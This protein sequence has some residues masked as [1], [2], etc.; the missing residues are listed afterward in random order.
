[1]VRIQVVGLGLSRCAKLAQPRGRCPQS[2]D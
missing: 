2:G 1:M